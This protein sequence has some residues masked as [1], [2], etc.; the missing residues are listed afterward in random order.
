MNK[1][2]VYYG[3]ISTRKYGTGNFIMS[4]E[5]LISF[6]KTQSFIEVRIMGKRS[7]KKTEVEKGRTL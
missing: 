5:T 4:L 6:L 1:A 3:K 7:K 2:I